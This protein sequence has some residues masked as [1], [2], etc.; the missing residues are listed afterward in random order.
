MDAFHSNP[1]ILL[2]SQSEFDRT[3]HLPLLP[4]PGNQTQDFTDEHRIHQDH[5]PV[6]VAPP[7]KARVDK[8][9]TKPL[10]VEDLLH[11][12]S[13]FAKV[14]KAFLSIEDQESRTVPEIAK[15]VSDMYTGQYADFEGVKVMSLPSYTFL[16]SYN[17]IQRMVNDVLQKHKAFWHPGRGSP[18][19]L[20]LN[21][22]RARREFPSN[23]R[24]LVR[25]RFDENMFYSRSK[26]QKK[27]RQ[28][29]KNRQVELDDNDALN[30]PTIL[31]RDDPG[32][33]IKS[34]ANDQT[35]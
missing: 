33:Y 30:H 19:Q 6:A 28:S 34:V 14:V 15:R 25:N 2:D 1:R 31:V 3:T 26:K 12:N 35:Y 17:S 27:A 5:S 11:D 9:N 21:E 16:C 23:N 20:N 32:A 8:R 7:K 10:A 4:I 18:Y 13:R 24:R 29:K 22:G